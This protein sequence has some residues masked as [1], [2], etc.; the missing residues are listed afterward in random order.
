MSRLSRTV[1]AIALAAS[2][3]NVQATLYCGR[4]YTELQ[5]NPGRPFNAVGFLNNGCTASL[6]DANHIVA[7][8]HCFV[9][10]TTTGQWQTGLRFYPNFHPSRVTATAAHVPRAD[11][12]RVVVGSRAGESVLGTG[13]DWG[14]AEVEN[15][16]DVAGLDLTPLSLAPAVPGIGTALQN[17]AYN[18]HHF[19]YNDNDSITW[20]N[21]SWDTA[22]CG[23][24][25]ANHGMW[26]INMHAPPL[27]DGT[28][29][30]TVGCNSRWASGMMHGSCTLN[31]VN[32]DVVLHDCDSA[33]GSSGSPLLYQDP[34]IGWQMIG[35]AHGSPQDF[36]L[37]TPT[38]TTRTAANATDNGGPSVERFRF[39]PRFASNVAVHRRPD[40]ASATMVFAVDSDSGRVVARS[41]TG[42]PSYN[43]NFGYWQDLGTP[44]AGATLQRVA[45]CSADSSARPQVFVTVNGNAIYSRTA[46]S[47]TTWSAWTPFGKPPGSTS[48]LDID[49]SSYNKNDCLLLAATDKGVFVSSKPTSTVWNGWFTV[50][51]GAF[52]AV[53]AL[54]DQGTIVAAMIDNAGQVWRT[55]LA[56]AGWAVPTM[57]PPPPGVTAWR[58]I[59]MTWDEAVRGFMLAVPAAPDNKLWFMPMYGPQAWVQWR[60]FDT[61]LWAPGA[62]AVQNAPRLLSISAS[63]WMEDAAGVTSPLIFA[64]DDQGNVYFIE[65]SRIKP[66]GPGWVL[67]WKSF[68]HESIAY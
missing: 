28:H 26:A 13:M 50:A 63:R 49:A 64:T 59:D 51:G 39:A 43:G 18:R 37:L 40:N 21:M 17:P 30:D 54:N 14:I 60:F 32:G 16:R 53:T 36:S 41:R 10:D 66:G 11:V 15:W 31:A 55:G 46:N 34:S 12:M 45:A 48:V 27:F 6:I 24:V 22:Q 8:G 4:T 65:F 47:A 3:V 33:G 44:L 29:P 23:W 61:H 1:V 42:A 19:P 20:D 58:D 67:D 2:A 38:C 35:V 56:P 9:V 25:G 7:A 5:T 68:N 62:N 52:K 57:I